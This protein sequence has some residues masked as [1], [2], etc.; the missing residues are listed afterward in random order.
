MRM[1]WDTQDHTQWMC[2]LAPGQQVVLVVRKTTSCATSTS[3][4][5]PKVVQKV[6]ETNS[7]YYKSSSCRLEVLSLQ[8]SITMVYSNGWHRFCWRLWWCGMVCVC[9]VSNSSTI[10]EHI[11]CRSIYG[12]GGCQYRSRNVLANGCWHGTILS[13][14]LLY[15]CN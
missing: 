2:K 15:C 3:V 1:F 9:M 4:A 7:F 12:Q 11:L 5:D 8:N 14:I 10:T 13:T 6:N